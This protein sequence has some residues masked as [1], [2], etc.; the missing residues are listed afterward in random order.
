ME[1]YH[2]NEST[3]TNA[4]PQVFLSLNE[5]NGPELLKISHVLF[6]AK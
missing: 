4:P 6:A 2:F 5:S 3:A 1:E